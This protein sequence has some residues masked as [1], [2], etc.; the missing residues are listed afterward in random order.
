MLS[1]LTCLPYLLY[2]FVTMKSPLVDFQKM[3]TSLKSYP[4]GIYLFSGL[5]GA[6]SPYQSSIYPVVEDLTE[7]GLCVIS[8]K[9]YPW[10]RNPFSSVHA[11][12]LTNLGEACG[13][14]AAF[15]AFQKNKHLRGIPI[16]LT[17]K[18]IAKARGTITGKAC[19]NFSNIKDDCQQEL[20]TNLYNERDEL[21]CTVE[22]TWLLSTKPD[23]SR[24]E[25][26][27]KSYKTE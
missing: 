1:I 7:D 2:S 14:I 8:M 5:V 15:A 21:V 11:A 20:I 17:T 27:S 26:G 18:F 6:Y 3:H 9:D 13:G 4:L 10:V 24:S 25:G 16:K 12:A 19:V 22:V 23:K